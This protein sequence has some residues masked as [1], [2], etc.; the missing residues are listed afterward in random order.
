MTGIDAAS[1]LIFFNKVIAF[2]TFVVKGYTLDSSSSTLQFRQFTR[3][4]SQIL[5]GHLAL[6][7]LPE[8]CVTMQE[9]CVGKEIGDAK[10]D[11]S[12]IKY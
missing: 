1:K 3:T 11:Y 9:P 4:H 8:P 2:G 7:P 6:P 10:L 5:S 12:V